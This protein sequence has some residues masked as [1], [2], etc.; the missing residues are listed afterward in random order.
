M[1]KLTPVL[2]VENI[3]ACLPFWVEHLGFEKTMEVP[4]GD[5]LGFVCLVNGNVEVMLQSNA[6]IEKD[7]PALAR[8]P[9]RAALYIEV[10]D[11]E[12]IAAI[13]EK[14]DVVVP[15][16][17]TFY[18]ATEIGVRDPAGNILPTTGHSTALARTCCRTAG[19]A[20]NTLTI[21]A[22]ACEIC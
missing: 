17:T 4:E 11:F 21:I 16:R 6:S 14:L 5:G 22:A 19:T 20:T 7:V 13:A 3:E 10:D 15:R 8:E 2:C 18:G 1:K 9:F 12:P